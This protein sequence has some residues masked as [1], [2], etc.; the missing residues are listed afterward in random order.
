MRFIAGLLLAAVLVTAFA[1]HEEWITSP[2]ELIRQ[3]ASR[4]EVS[5]RFQDS[6][7]GRFDATVFLFTCIIVTPLVV[8]ALILV[9]LIIMMAL[10]V[11]VFQLSRS[12]GLPDPL[13]AGFVSVAVAGFAWTYAELWVPRSLRLLGTIARAWVVSTT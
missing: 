7:I 4:P 12:A 13:T 11:T 2:T 10:Q 9:L 6:E 1:V 5:A 8:V 3:L